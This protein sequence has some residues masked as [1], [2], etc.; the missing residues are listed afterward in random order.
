MGAWRELLEEQEANGFSTN[1]SSDNVC[2]LCIDDPALADYVARDPISTC[3]FCGS[4]NKLGMAVGDLFRYM[5]ECLKAEWDDPIN[6]VAW[7]RGFVPSPSGLF[8][9]DDLLSMVDEPLLH[10]DLRQEFIIAFDRMWCQQN[11]YRLEHSKVLIHSWLEFAEVVRTNRRFLTPLDTTAHDPMDDE[12]L[13]T[14]KVLG[15]VGDAIQR[16]DQR[17]LK[18]SAD[19]RITRARVHESSE[20]L[21]TAQT[22]GS[23][24]SSRAKHN[25]MSG[26]GISMFYGAED[27]DTAIAEIRSNSNQVVTVG[28]WTPTCELVYLDLLAAQ[29]IPS[30]FDADERSYRTE[31]R[32]LIGFADDLARPIDVED[33][34][35]EYIPTQIV[36]EYIRDH[37]KTSDGHQIDAI[38]YGSALD[39]QGVCWVVFAGPD[40]CGDE[41]D[42]SEP[43]LVLDPN[44]V[45]RYDW[46]LQPTSK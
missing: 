36:T 41:G 13:P 9:S 23:P 10:E 27:A 24:P 22:L 1:R 40:D 14:G 15:A 33:R 42:N 43:L 31:L 5:N 28:S 44:S 37:L 29:P 17:V 38:R 19:L 8:D 7:E 20:I 35:L 2:R 39:E 46:G 34:G 30:I 6:M 45:R 3:D 18:R 32:F 11:P 21:D 12:L 16:S 25:R 4:T 26:E